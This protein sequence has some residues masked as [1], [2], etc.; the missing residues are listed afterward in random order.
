VTFSGLKI[1]GT[2][3][4]GPLTASADISVVSTARAEVE[5]EGINEAGKIDGKEGEEFWEE[6]HEASS[7]F[8]LILIALHI[9][10]VVISSRLHKENLVKAMITGKKNVE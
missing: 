6:I 9:L 5:D 7:Y 10:G 1:Y 8:M 2:E 3:G 4:H